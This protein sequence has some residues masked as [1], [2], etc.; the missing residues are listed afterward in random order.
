MVAQEPVRAVES[1]LDAF[2]LG[3]TVNTFRVPVNTLY[4][5]PMDEQLL[6]PQVPELDA[7]LGIKI[8]VLDDGF[9]RVVDYMGNDAAIVQAAR[10][11]YGGAGTTTRSDDAML[12]P[13]SHAAP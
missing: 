10:V 2:S 7:I 13:P 8:P 6:R 3:H 12:Y 5:R 11:S 1:Y 4:Y 9:V